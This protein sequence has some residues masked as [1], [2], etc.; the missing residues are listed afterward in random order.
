MSEYVDINSMLIYSIV[1]ASDK[2]YKYFICYKN[3]DY[4]IKPLPIIVLKNAYVK[5]YNGKTKLMNF[6]LNMMIAAKV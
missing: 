6:V 1:F 2:N 3:G 5:S 4:K